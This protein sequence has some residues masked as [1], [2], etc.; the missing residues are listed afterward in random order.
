MLIYVGITQT[1][2]IWN[3]FETKWKLSF[4][5][6]RKVLSIILLKTTMVSVIKFD[7]KKILLSFIH[8]TVFLAVHSWILPWRN[9]RSLS[10]QRKP[11]N[12][13][14]FIRQNVAEAHKKEVTSNL[15]KRQTKECFEH[16][17]TR[18]RESGFLTFTKNAKLRLCV[19]TSN[20]CTARF[21]FAD[22][23][24]KR[25]INQPSSPEIRLRSRATLCTL[26]SK[27]YR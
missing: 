4:I 24:W 22:Y 17:R 10:R 15:A 2:A 12:A 16:S 6:H 7:H 9:L 25:S 23:G 11:W 19:D 1:R 27:P 8:S 26:R 18:I 3:F 21:C 13:K 20:P 5:L 14:L